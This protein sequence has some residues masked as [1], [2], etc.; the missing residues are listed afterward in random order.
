MKV[1]APVINLLVQEVL[2]WTLV[3]LLQ[4]EHLQRE[5]EFVMLPEMTQFFTAP[6]QMGKNYL[7]RLGLVCLV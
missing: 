2:K 3:H 5:Q 1:V 6:S 4:L 7:C